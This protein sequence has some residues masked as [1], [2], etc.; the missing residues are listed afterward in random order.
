M[1]LRRSRSRRQTACVVRAA[2]AEE[3]VDPDPSFRIEK[4]LRHSACA[5]RRLHHTAKNAI[6][7]GLRDNVAS[8]LAMNAPLTTY[9]CSCMVTERRALLIL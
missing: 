1:R 8:P 7:R 3:L 5:H 9:A 4:V 2:A 6:F